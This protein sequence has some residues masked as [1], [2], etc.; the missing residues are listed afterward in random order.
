M[1]GSRKW[2]ITDFATSIPSLTIQ[3]LASPPN[4]IDQYSTKQTLVAQCKHLLAGLQR[5]VPCANDL[6]RVCPNLVELRLVQPC[7][8]DETVCLLLSL[9]SLQIFLIRSCSTLTAGGFLVCM[10][11]PCIC[12][13]LLL[14][15]CCIAISDVDVLQ[16][17]CSE[18]SFGE[19][20]LK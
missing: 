1:Y 13:R 18:D 3:C 4:L 2:K 5:E 19:L 7:F 10:C 14:L 12:L 9:V 8:L 11:L 20:Q 6:V 16:A 15:D 17:R